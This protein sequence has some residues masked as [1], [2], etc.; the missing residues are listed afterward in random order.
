MKK[1]GYLHVAFIKRGLKKRKTQQNSDNSV[2]SVCRLR[3]SMKDTEEK[4][5]GR[6]LGPEGKLAKEVAQIEHYCMG[7]GF[8]G[9]FVEKEGRPMGPICDNLGQTLLIKRRAGSGIMISYLA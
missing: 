2:R 5:G 8:D 6:S 7:L 9:L 1:K 3:R 4:K